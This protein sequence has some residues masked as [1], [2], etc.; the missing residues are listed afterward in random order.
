MNHSLTVT[1]HE[2]VVEATSVLLVFSFI[3]S[4]FLAGKT[5]SFKSAQTYCPPPLRAHTYKCGS[6]ED[7]T[8][9]PKSS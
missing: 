6:N 5:V 8:A 9:D 4:F 7:E 2:V 3:L 1:K